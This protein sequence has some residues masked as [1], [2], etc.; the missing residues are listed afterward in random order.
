[1]EDGSFY[2]ERRRS[3]SSELHHL[4]VLL[5]LQVAQKKED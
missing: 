2:V 4:M 5:F 1:M 3:R